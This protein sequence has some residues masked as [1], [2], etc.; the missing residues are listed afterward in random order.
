MES[1]KYLFAS[2]DGRVIVATEKEFQ[3]YLEKEKESKVE[4]VDASQVHPTF[5][6]GNCTIRG[7]LRC[8]KCKTQRYCSVACQREDWKNHKKICM[9]KI[10][11]EKP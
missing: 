5:K 9:N 10:K 2:V 3:D 4:I 6:C 1:K 8:G 11:D 7:D